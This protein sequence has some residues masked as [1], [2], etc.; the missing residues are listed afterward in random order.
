[1]VV[2]F[3][4][5]PMTIMGG[6]AAAV[7]FGVVGVIMRFWPE[8]I[9]PSPFSYAF[10]GCLLALGIVVSFG[11]WAGRF[12]RITYRSPSRSPLGTNRRPSHRMEG[13]APQNTPALGRAVADN[14]A[15]FAKA[16]IRLARHLLRRCLELV[17]S[18]S[19]GYLQTVFPLRVNRVNL[20]VR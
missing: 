12:V 9:E 7:L 17:P 1:M 14:S 3:W 2:T 11:S 10:L 8:T 15:R 4:V 20:P 18:S 13:T 16:A 6:V 19:A 5:P